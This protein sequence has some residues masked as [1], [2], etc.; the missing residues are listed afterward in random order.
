M[1]EPAAKLSS[2]LI[3]WSLVAIG[4]GLL[5]PF[6]FF[7]HKRASAME[8]WIDCRPYGSGS[9]LVDFVRIAVGIRPSNPRVYSYRARAKSYDFVRDA[10]L[11]WLMVGGVAVFLG[12]FLV[13]IVSDPLNAKVPNAWQGTAMLVILVVGATSALITFSRRYLRQMRDL[14]E[15]LS[16]LIEFSQFGMFVR[17][18]GYTEVIA[19]TW[20]KH[21]PNMADPQ[22][23]LNRS[24]IHM[25]LPGGPRWYDLTAMER[26]D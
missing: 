5:Y 22:T 26:S 1:D 10:R 14:R 4:Y 17:N 8:P 19:C 15:G 20:R 25:D 23:G 21:N 9:A 13:L 24:R 12:G 16:D 2:V 11:M 18:Q 3:L 7:G 6:E